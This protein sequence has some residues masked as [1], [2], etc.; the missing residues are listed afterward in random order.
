MKDIEYYLTIVIKYMIDLLWYK[1]N[2]NERVIIFL[3]FNAGNIFINFASVS[4]HF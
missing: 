3:Y 1:M 4:S 2:S